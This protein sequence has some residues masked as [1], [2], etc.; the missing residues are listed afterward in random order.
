[1]AR[2]ALGQNDPSSDFLSADRIAHRLHRQTELFA[3]L[4]AAPRT[5]EMPLEWY[6]RGGQPVVDRRRK[7]RPGSSAQLSSHNLVQSLPLFG[8]RARVDPRLAG[9]LSFVDRSWPSS[10]QRES[11]AVKRYRAASSR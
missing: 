2:E 10:H 1:M 11:E 6:E 9:A 4:V 5:V 8:G 3:V 7:Y